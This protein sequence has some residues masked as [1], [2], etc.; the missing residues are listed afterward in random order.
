MKRMI[1][2]PKRSLLTTLLQESLSFWKQAPF[3]L[4]PEML[5]VV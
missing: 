1:H 4:P 2:M 3:S 5:E